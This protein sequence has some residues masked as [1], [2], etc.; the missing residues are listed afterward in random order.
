MSRIVADTNIHFGQPCIAGTRVP[1]YVVLDLVEAGISFDIIVRDYY[2]DISVDD[3]KACI[4][5]A[6]DIV[7]SEEIHISEAKAL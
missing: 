2:P 5:Y 7:Q 6:K 3:V 4:K 1:V